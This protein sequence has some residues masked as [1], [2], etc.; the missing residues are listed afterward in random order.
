[1]T[2]PNQGPWEWADALFLEENGSRLVVQD[3]TIFELTVWQ[4]STS[5]IISRLRADIL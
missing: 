5:T 2:V 1:M 4:I 3:E